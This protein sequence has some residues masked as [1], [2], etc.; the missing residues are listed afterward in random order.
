MTYGPSGYYSN[1]YPQPNPSGR[2]AKKNLR[3]N[4]PLLFITLGVGA[5]T[6]FIGL[7]I[8]N[9]NSHAALNPL[10]FGLLV[11][12][13]AL[14]LLL[15]V[16]LFSTL[17]HTYERSRFGFLD[18][19]PVMFAGIA[20][21][22]ALLFGLGALF[23]F[24]YGLNLSAKATEPTSYIFVIDDSGSME[25][26]D[27]T[28]QRYAAIETLLADKPADFPYMVYG[29]SNDVYVIKEMA[30]VSSGVPHLTG[31][32]YGGT[33][34]KGALERVI[35]DYKSRA[36]DG[37]SA[38]RVIFLTDGAP[39]DMDF[40]F[41]LDPV[42]RKFASSNVVVSAVGLGDVNDGLMQKIAESTGGV[43]VQVSDA[44]ELNTAMARAS[45]A[46]SER[47]LVSY[48]HVARLGWL[49]GVLRVLFLGILGVLLGFACSLAYGVPDSNPIILLTSLIKG[50]AGG[51]VMELGTLIGLPNKLVW[52]LA[53]LLFAALIA[54]KGEELKPVFADP[55]NGRISGIDDE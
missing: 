8:Y 12:I 3:L 49:Y 4:L 17:T 11:A 37:G 34:I 46:H 27:P 24:I 42:L 36:W 2:K 41:Q 1:G 30:P 21:A 7:L 54:L 20:G 14:P 28:Q 43:Y 44:A 35:N 45:T 50:L 26:N 25:G 48:R 55:S 33:A 18:N 38:P 22:M 47:D 52:L 39:T 9:A 23:Q 32:A 6:W 15:A 40:M 29:F 10:Q 53:W 16:F 31:N 51:L 5:A 19:K 13:L